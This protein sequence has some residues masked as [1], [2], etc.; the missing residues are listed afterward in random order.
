MTLNI[1]LVAEEAAGVQTLRTLAAGPHNL[2]G[3]LAQPDRA[4][5]NGSSV[6]GV[7]RHLGVETWPAQQVKDPQF[8]DHLAR[9]PIDLLLNVHSLYVIHPAL[10]TAPRIGSFNL[11]PGPLPRYAGLNAVSWALYQGETHHGVTLHWMVDRI[12]A[13]PLVSQTLFPIEDEDTALT[14]SA[15]CVRLG[16]PLIEELLDIAA[17]NVQDIPR[18]PQDLNQRAYF[19]P[20]VPQNG[21]LSWSRPAREVLNF[22]R[23]CDYL[24][25]PSPWGHPTSRLNGHAMEILKTLPT[26][27]ACQAEPGAITTTQEGKPWVACADEWVQVERVR[28]DGHILRADEV[29]EKGKCFVEKHE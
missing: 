15:K 16:L 25:F 6:W 18:H 27:V 4:K 19:G 7:A 28:V 23:A 8:A 14:L 24:P 12:D 1:L 29:L 26:G 5:K 21:R 2:I 9:Y 10:V 17:V 20:E 22:V 13:G 3:V 11:H